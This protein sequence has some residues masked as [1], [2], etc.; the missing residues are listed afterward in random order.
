MQEALRVADSVA[1][2]V[3]TF[4]PGTYRLVPKV[5]NSNYLVQRGANNY[6]VEKGEKAYCTSFLAFCLL[7]PV[8]T[9]ISGLPSCT[10]VG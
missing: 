8:F 2:C 9:L 3:V 1:S 7:P 6:P 4:K 10:S 5:Q